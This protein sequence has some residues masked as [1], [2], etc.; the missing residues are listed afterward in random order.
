MTDRD[1]EL[2]DWSARWLRAQGELDECRK[3]IRCLAHRLTLKGD[4]AYAQAA[5][6]SAGLTDALVE[7]EATGRDAE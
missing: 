6:E 7:R 2:K 5:L 4:A 3:V 1:E